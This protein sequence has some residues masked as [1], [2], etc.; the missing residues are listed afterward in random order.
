MGEEEIPI[1]LIALENEPA[2]SYI[3]AVVYTG[4]PVN[5]NPG[6]YPKC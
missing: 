5:V 2:C 1:G 4:D 6:E 3:C